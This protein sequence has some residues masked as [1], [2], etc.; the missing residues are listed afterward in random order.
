MHALSRDGNRQQIF[1]IFRL[2]GAALIAKGLDP[3]SLSV[4]NFYYT[5]GIKGLAKLLS[6]EA[7]DVSFPAAVFLATAR[8]RRLV[9]THARGSSLFYSCSAFAK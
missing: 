5:M 8:R 2:C 6:D 9:W 4:C 1:F 7:P 3:I